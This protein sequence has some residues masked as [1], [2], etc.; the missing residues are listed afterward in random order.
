MAHFAELNEDNIV[1]RVIPFSDSLEEID[2]ADEL[3]GIWKRTSYN[4]FGNVHRLD[5]EPF[6]FN[7]AGIG[8]KYDEVRDAFIPP[9]PFP[10]W[11]LDEETCLWQSPIPYPGD[12]ENHG[13]FWSEELY[14]WIKL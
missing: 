12:E 8:Y 14:S 11:V 5:G 3:G 2:I 7:Y 9:K 4:T 10:S 13:Y 6:R 1:L